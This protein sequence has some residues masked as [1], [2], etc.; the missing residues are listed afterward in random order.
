MAVPVARRRPAFRGRRRR[1][2][3]F[4]DSA[5]DPLTQQIESGTLS[6]DRAGDGPISSAAISGCSRGNAE[7]SAGGLQPGDRRGARWWM[8]TSCA[9]EL[10]RAPEGSTGHRRMP[11]RQSPWAAYQHAQPTSSAP[12]SGSRRATTASGSPTRCGPPAHD[13][14]YGG[15]MQRGLALA[16]LGDDSAAH[17]P[18]S[19]EATQ[20]RS[21]H[22]P[23]GAPQGVRSDPAQTTPNC[24]NRGQTHLTTS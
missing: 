11:P 13:P 6:G 3:D 15:R 14:K 22:P 1:H 5:R 9:A 8:P 2:A 18:P 16:K 23:H 10:F 17:C 4:Y 20:D 12:R 24:K 7:Q 19:D 21:A